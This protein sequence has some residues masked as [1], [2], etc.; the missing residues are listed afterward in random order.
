MVALT[1]AVT[2]EDAVDRA[3]RYKP[4]C[5]RCKKLLPAKRQLTCGTGYA[6]VGNGKRPRK[7]CYDCCAEMDK[8]FMRKH[9]RIDLY[10]TWEN[11]LGAHGFPPA[12]IASRYGTVTNWPGT[13]VR[14]HLNVWRARHNMAGWQY[15]TWFRF[16]GHWWHGVR[17]GDNTQI[18]H[19]K[20]TKSLAN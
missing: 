19:C 12:T 17:F 18:V 9:G 5:S 6:L 10:L 2:L 20:R 4:K 3:N 1:R 8:A 13:F 7:V 16:D 15:H 14:R 11:D